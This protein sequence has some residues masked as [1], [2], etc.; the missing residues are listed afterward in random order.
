MKSS[1]E[2]AVLVSCS[3]PE[4]S[5]YLFFFSFVSSH[6]PVMDFDVRMILTTTSGGRHPRT[7]PTPQFLTRAS[8]AGQNGV[9]FTKKCNDL[10][11]YHTYRRSSGQQTGKAPQP[12]VDMYNDAHMTPHFD[13]VNRAHVGMQGL[14][15][16][17][18]HG[19]GHLLRNFRLGGGRPFKFGLLS[20]RCKSRGLG[21]AFIEW[22]GIYLVFADR[23]S[24]YISH[25]DEERLDL[26]MLGVREK[27][28][29]LRVSF[30][31]QERIATGYC[32]SAFWGTRQ[33]GAHCKVLTTEIELSWRLTELQGRVKKNASR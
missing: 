26:T 13:Q 4:R 23:N 8:G 5:G 10:A 2:L 30:P 29:N 14:L 11:S 12:C 31:T 33:R 15:D 17:S 24:R 21:G 7:K 19:N 20:R 9:A 22:N 27:L 32:V 18:Q 1:E 25:D 6:K 28:C 3:A 16:P